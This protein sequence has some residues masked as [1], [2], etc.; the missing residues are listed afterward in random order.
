MSGKRKNQASHGKAHKH[1]KP[2]VSAL[3]ALASLGKQAIS[4]KLNTMANT[5][6]KNYNKP[7]KTA[8]TAKLFQIAQSTGQHHDL[9]ESKMFMKLGGKRRLSK[10]TDKIKYCESQE[11]VSTGLEGL[12]QVW[13]P[14]TFLSLR[15]FIDGTNVR[16]SRDLTAYKW[17][18]YNPNEKVTGGNLTTAGLIANNTAINIEKYHA[19]LELLNMTNTTTTVYV[20]LMKCVQ[21]TEFTPS[22]IWAKILAAERLGQ[23]AAVPPVSTSTSTVNLAAPLN[24]FVGQ[25]PNACRGFSKFW[26]IERVK[27]IV[28]QG[29]D[30]HKIQLDVNVNKK[31]TLEEM[32]S[33]YDGGSNLFYKGV[34]VMPMIIARGQL[35]GISDASGAELATEVTYARTKL[36]LT[37]VCKYWI[38]VPKEPPSAPANYTKY[39]L[40][41]APTHIV[42]ER[43]INDVDVTGIL[44]TV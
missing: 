25:F 31:F 37:N 6:Y 9:S 13:Q 39:D 5:A 17:F 42:D 3:T 8:P 11:F 12:Q 28:L 23:V 10:S 1:H 21:N 20:Y 14:K 35:V 34:S 26:K 27:K 4:Y 2:G 24:T 30:A 18:D 32:Q 16:N 41:S 38:S 29:G 40:V 44:N 19:A 36:G 33:A 7:K 43:F 22:E 15:S